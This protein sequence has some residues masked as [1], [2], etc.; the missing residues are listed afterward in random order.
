[1]TGITNHIAVAVDNIQRSLDYTVNTNIR[2]IELASTEI[3]VETKGITT[4]SNYMI[5][6][7]REVREH[8][9]KGHTELAVAYDKI[10]ALE[11]A[12]T[13]LAVEMAAMKAEFFASMARIQTSLD[14]MHET[15][16]SPPAIEHTPKVIGI[17]TQDVVIQIRAGG[18]VQ[19]DLASAT[20]RTEERGPQ[21]TEVVEVPASDL[22]EERRPQP[23]EVPEASASDQTEE[24]RP[25]PTEVPEA[26]ASDQTEERRPQPTEVPEASASDQTEERRPQPTEVPEAS[27]SDQ[28]EERR[29]QPTE[30]QE[31]SASDQTE[32]RR[33]QPTEVQ[34]VSASDQTEERRPQ[35][36][37][38]QE[39]SASDQTEERG[40]QPTEVQEVPASDQTEERGPQPTDDAD[41]Y[42]AQSV[43]DE[44]QVVGAGSDGETGNE[45]AFEDSERVIPDS[46][47]RR[48]FSRSSTSAREP[49]GKPVVL[50]Y[51]RRHQFPPPQPTDVREAAD[52]L[53]NLNRNEPGELQWPSESELEAGENG[54]EPTC[55]KFPWGVRLVPKEESLSPAPSEASTVDPESLDVIPSSM[56]VRRS[57]RP[58]KAKFIE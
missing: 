9:T 23:T 41:H 52:L 48:L 7:L 6:K 33:P 12:N 31:V 26:S 4:Q 58:R 36:T 40:P 42:V 24:R 2:T 34:E 3:N 53:M 16:V 57:T 54:V 51:C 55:V 45:S 25:Q 47:L 38:V 21:P 43:V 20:D 27:A 14:K 11:V 49:N 30:V 10:A 46:K 13:K 1:M 37:E 56:P 50:D 17:N 32:E 44:S 18:T 5:T 28:T 39:V 35:P 8:Q 29:P 19:T 22:T 15:L